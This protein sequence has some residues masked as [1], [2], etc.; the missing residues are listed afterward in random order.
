MS[1]RKSVYRETFKS[2]TFFTDR[3][4][5]TDWVNKCEVIY[6][7]NAGTNDDGTEYITIKIDGVKPTDNEQD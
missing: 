1:K 6:A 5:V 3:K 4:Q 7:I 2:G